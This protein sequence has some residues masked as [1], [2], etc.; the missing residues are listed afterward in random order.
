MQQREFF[1]KTDSPKRHLFDG[2]SLVYFKKK[3]E[4]FIKN[5]AVKIRRFYMLYEMRVRIS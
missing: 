1:S 5:M 2:A 4:N 3:T